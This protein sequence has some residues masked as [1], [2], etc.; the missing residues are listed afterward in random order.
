M[1]AANVPVATTI[2]TP[3]LNILRGIAQSLRLRIT[4]AVGPL[5]PESSDSSPREQLSSPG[6]QERCDRQGR[7]QNQ[8][9][10]RARS[11]GR[12]IVV[13]QFAVDAAKM[14]RNVMVHVKD[15]G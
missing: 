6:R 12:F 13:M 11:N 3:I 15:M 1:V 7:R 2:A 9:S 4:N 10:C 8:A 14:P 5:S